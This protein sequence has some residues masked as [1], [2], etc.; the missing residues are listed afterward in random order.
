ME[1]SFQV[2]KEFDLR[3]N[4]SY[5]NDFQKRFG[6]TNT[7]YFLPTGELF[8]NEIKQNYLQIESLNLKTTLSQN[9]SKNYLENVL[10]F[11]G[12]WNNSVRILHEI[13]LQFNKI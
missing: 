7:Q 5:L 2:E 1:S 12:D 6:E 9:S 10:E 8:L 4:I 13:L 3:V 11:K